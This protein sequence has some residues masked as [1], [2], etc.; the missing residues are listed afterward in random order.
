MSIHTL[1]RKLCVSQPLHTVFDFF[2]RAENLEKITPP[3]M[4]FRI[5]TTLPVE[6]KKGAN[7]EYSIRVRGIPLRW[8]TLIEE[9]SPPYRFVDVQA[10]GPYKLWHHTHTFEEFEGGTAIMD[11]VRYQLP[12]GPLGELV[13]ALRVKSDVEQIFDYRSKQVPLFLL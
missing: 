10:K 3:W 5:L 2:S 13:H 1:E 9:W 4:H 6:M 12:F 8:H 7:I 11:T